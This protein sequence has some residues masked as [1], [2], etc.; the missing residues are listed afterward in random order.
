MTATPLTWS[1]ND[2]VF[3]L[4]VER[5]CNKDFTY[6]GIHIKKEAWAFGVH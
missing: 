6:N 3:A 1:F 4:G 5:G 2:F